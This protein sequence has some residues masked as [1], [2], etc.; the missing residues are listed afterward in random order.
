M[1]KPELLP[2]PQLDFFLFRVVFGL[3]FL[4]VSNI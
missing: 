1:A 4:M 2:T 3:L